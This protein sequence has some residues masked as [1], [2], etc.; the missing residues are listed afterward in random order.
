METLPNTHFKIL[1]IKIL[2]KRI[3]IYKRSIKKDLKAENGIY[4]PKFGQTLADAN[5]FIDRYKQNEKKHMKG[6]MML[7]GYYT[8]FKHKPF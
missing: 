8:T 2:N 4:S 6:C 3:D 7:G 5:P 1:G